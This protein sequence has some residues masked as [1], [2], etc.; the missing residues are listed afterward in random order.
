MENGGMNREMFLFEKLDVY[1]MAVE[2]YSDVRKV[3]FDRSDGDRI[4]ARQLHRAVLSISL[5]IAEG[6]G[7][8]GPKDRRNFLIIARGSLYECVAIFNVL[9]VNKTLGIEEH[10]AM[11]LKSIRISKMLLSMIRLLDKGIP[12][13]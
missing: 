7:K 5:N 8:S 1:Q 13:K 12:K 2:L 6:S 4:I 10:S 3:N 9:K 11:Y